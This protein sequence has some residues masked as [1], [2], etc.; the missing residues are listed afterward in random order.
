MTADHIPQAVIKAPLLSSVTAQPPQRSA[1][2]PFSQAAGCNLHTPLHYG[3]EP[4]TVQLTI[5]YYWAL[6]AGLGTLEA[7]ELGPRPLS[8]KARHLQ[9]ILQVRD[10]QGRKQTCRSG[11]RAPPCCEIG[12]HGFQI[13]IGTSPLDNA[14][15]AF[16]VG[17]G[18]AWGVGGQDG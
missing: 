2:L 8:S 12:Q 7:E 3:R 16:L 15:D 1:P 10:Q 17:K 6:L 14:K 5:F 18:K 11:R 13:S 9:P 4:S